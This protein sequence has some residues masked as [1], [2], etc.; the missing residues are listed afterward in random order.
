MS[1]VFQLGSTTIAK[2][3]VFGWCISK[4]GRTYIVNDLP[5]DS[6]EDLANGNYPAYMEDFKNEMRDILIKSKEGSGSAP[7]EKSV[8]GAKVVKE[9]TM[10]RSISLIKAEIL[11][12][13]RKC[14]YFGLKVGELEPYVWLKL[15]NEPDGSFSYEIYS[16]DKSYRTRVKGVEATAL[17]IARIWW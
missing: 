12:R 8:S 4:D 1:T 5:V 2:D 15:L 17:Y 14:G 9:S 10:A 11:S 3:M 6:L 16:R 7:L 13:Q